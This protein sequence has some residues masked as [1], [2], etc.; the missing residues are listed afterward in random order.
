MRPDARLTGSQRG[1]SGSDQP[2][3]RKRLNAGEAP[4]AGNE[5]PL[6]IL[7]MQ[8][9][10]NQT[11]RR[12]HPQVLM[13]LV[14]DQQTH[15]RGRADDRQAHDFGTAAERQTNHHYGRDIGPVRTPEQDSGAGD[16]TCEYRQLRQVIGWADVRM[17]ATRVGR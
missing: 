6:L 3:R 2:P 5:I 17:R 14:L 16:R 10:L 15:F 7:L 8:Y 4:P 9:C 11:G 12:G 1:C 13:S